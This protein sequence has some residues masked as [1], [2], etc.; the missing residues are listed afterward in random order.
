ME[1]YKV[2]LIHGNG[3]GTSNDNWIPYL[4]KELEKVG[5]TAIAE[6]FPDNRLARE[7]YWLPFIKDHLKA[8]EHTII[9][10]HSSG[11]V[12]A[13]RFAENSKLLGS[14]LIGACYTDLGLE[15]EKVSGYYDR[16]WDWNAIKRNQKWI[17]LFASSDDPWIPIEEPRHI[18]ENLQTE[19]YEYHDQGHFGGDYFKGEFPE[20]LSIIK[21]KLG[22]HE[23]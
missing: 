22:I 12:A 2:I 21:Q 4:K 11:A 5:V 3:G 15:S 10:G 13:M 23:N 6:E 20:V 18:H 19:Y 8:D 17:V 14:I 9:V 16:P 1:K 7:V